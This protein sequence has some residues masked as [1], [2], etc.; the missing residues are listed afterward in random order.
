MY[1]E[2]EAW[3]VEVNTDLTEGRGYQ[4]PLHIC[5]KEATARRLGKKAD[6]QGMDAK[7]HPVKLIKVGS[8]WYGPVQIRP[9]TKEDAHAQKLLDAKREVVE[10]AR[11]AGLSDEDIAALRSAV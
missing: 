8:C 10:R 5:D 6:V 11:A 1:E 9:E 3:M 7:T 4:V 2:R